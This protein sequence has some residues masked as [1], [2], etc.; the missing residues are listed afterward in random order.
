MAKIIGI[1]VRPSPGEQVGDLQGQ[2]SS[3]TIFTR[4]QIT[5]LIVNTD[6]EAPVN[7]VFLK[8]PPHGHQH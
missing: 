5:H 8:Q 2:S 4:H 7:V 6:A 3:V 1:K